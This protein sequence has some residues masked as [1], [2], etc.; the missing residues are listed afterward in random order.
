[1]VEGKSASRADQIATTLRQ[2][3]TTDFKPGDK[4]PGMHELRHRFGVSINTIGTALDILASEGLLDKRRGSGVYVEERATRRRIGILSELDLFDP[5]IGPHWRSVAGAVKAGLEAAGH[6]PQFY[7][8]NAEPGPGASD[9]PTC[10]RF[11]EDA[12]AGLT[13]R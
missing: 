13:A 3:L 9:V 8:G 4:L 1:M 7:V 10:P 5:R 12:A 6:R 2:E 11:W